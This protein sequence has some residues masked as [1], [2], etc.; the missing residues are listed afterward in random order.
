MEGGEWWM[1]NGEFRS[2]SHHVHLLGRYA[3]FYLFFWFF[4]FP[5]GQKEMKH[6]SR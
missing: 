4:L 2:I 6:Q 3:I 5:S 1:V